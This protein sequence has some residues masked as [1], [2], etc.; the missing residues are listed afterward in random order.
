MPARQVNRL[1]GKEPAV[2]LNADSFHAQETQE[3]FL[4]DVLGRGPVSHH[5]ISGSK[6]EVAMGQDQGR[7]APA[8]PLPEESIDLA[9]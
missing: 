2:G 1:P 7:Q 6:D 8:S 5:P 4:H 9:P 3:D